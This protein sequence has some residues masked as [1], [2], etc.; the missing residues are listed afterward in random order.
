MKTP[1]QAIDLHL[2]G[3][4][5]VAR[6]D[7]NGSP[8]TTTFRSSPVVVYMRWRLLKGA[9]DCLSKPFTG[10]RRLDACGSR[11]GRWSAA[12]S[13][14]AHSRA[15]QRLCPTPT[16]CQCHSGIRMCPR[17]EAR[18]PAALCLTGPGRTRRYRWGIQTPTP[19]QT[20]SVAEWLGC[21]SRR[22]YKGH[23]REPR[24]EWEAFVRFHTGRR[25]VVAIRSGNV[26]R[27]PTPG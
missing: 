12:P 8:C 18:H 7:W 3:T 6:Y 23:V 19:A 22:K 1:S 27:D 14:P 4:A 24:R 25:A 2:Q 10:P 21:R 11:R 17:A 9:A 16:M 20:K 13:R 5:W 26:G 15:A